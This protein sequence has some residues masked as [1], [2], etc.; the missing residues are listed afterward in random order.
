MTRRSTSST[1]RRPPSAGTRGPGQR[2]ERSGRLRLMLSGVTIRPAR[3]RCRA[4][5]GRADRRADRAGRQPGGGGRRRGHRHD[6]DPRQRLRDRAFRLARQDRTH[7]RHPRPAGRLRGR[8]RGARRALAG[9][10]PGRARRLRRARRQ[11]G[12]DQARRRGGRR[13]AHRGG[14]GRRRGRAGHP[15]PRG[16]GYGRPGR[17]H[18]RGQ[19]HAG[20]PAGPRRPA[21]YGSGPAA[22]PGGQ[23]GGRRSRRGGRRDRRPPA[24]PV[25]RHRI[26][27]TGA[28]A[29]RGHDRPAG[30]I[31]HRAAGQRAQLVLH[32]E[33]QLL[34]GG[35]RPGAAAGV[36]GSVD[37]ADRRHGRPAGRAHLRRPAPAAAHRGRHH[38]GLRV[39]RGRRAVRGQR[40]LARRQPAR[41]CSAGPGSSG[42]PIRCSAPRWTA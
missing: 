41:P 29:R 13:A 27:G 23:R 36:A 12:A 16:A 10:R 42:A 15:G 9:G 21:G 4:G 6:A 34:P 39:Q 32:A 25:Q 31:R 19:G 26:Q 11:R 1:R 14:R 3:G 18:R 37:P 22:F 38:A 17:R 8:D 7:L 33:R 28:A 30:L 40:A 5:R 24:A 2:R 20:R 35:H